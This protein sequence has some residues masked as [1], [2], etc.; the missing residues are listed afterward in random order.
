MLVPGIPPR[1]PSSSGASLFASQMYA[2]YYSDSWC[3]GYTISLVLTGRTLSLFVSLNNL[4]TLRF[5]PTF[6]HLCV[7]SSMGPNCRGR[8]FILCPVPYSSVSFS[9]FAK[10]SAKCLY[11]HLLSFSH[12]CHSQFRP[13]R[14]PTRHRLPRNMPATSSNTCHLSD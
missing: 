14:V 9:D 7:T 4:N 12:S 6:A 1:A 10:S 2:S 8:G 13:Q 3:Q 5:S 11:V